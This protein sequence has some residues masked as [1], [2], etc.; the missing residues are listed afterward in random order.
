[1]LRVRATPDEL[2]AFDL[3]AK[4]SGEQRS[5][6]IRATLTAATEVPAELF[7]SGR[8]DEAGFQIRALPVPAYGLLVIMPSTNRSV[9]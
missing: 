2:K 6:W 1:M 5:E 4:A 7:S 3:A 8:L 9:N